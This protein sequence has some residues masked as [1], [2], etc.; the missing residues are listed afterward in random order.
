VKIHAFDGMAV[1]NAV[2]LTRPSNQDYNKK[3]PP[4]ERISRFSSPFKGK[5][6]LP[7][8]NPLVTG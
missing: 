3:E 6:D 7:D 8:Y 1:P 2:R 4:Q 5:L